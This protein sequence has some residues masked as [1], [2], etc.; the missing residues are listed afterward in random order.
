MH[1]L[2]WLWA[3]AAFYL[4]KLGGIFKGL[5]YNIITKFEMCRGLFEKQPRMFTLNSDTKWNV[6]N[7][8]MKLWLR[9]NKRLN[10]LLEQGKTFQLP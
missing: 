4:H 6:S 1:L 2:Q 3:T 8:V 10:L 5:F 7:G 9:M